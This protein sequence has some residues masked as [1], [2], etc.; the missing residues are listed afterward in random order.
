MTC[1]WL[2][3]SSSTPWRRPC[4][5]IYKILSGTLQSYLWTMKV[6][7]AATLCG[8][9]IALFLSTP[10]I[11]AAIHQ[12][13]FVGIGGIDQWIG[14]DSEN[15]EN[16]IVLVVHGGPGEAQ[17]P[18]AAHYRTWEKQFTV[19]QW[20]QRGAGRT[21]GRYGTQTPDVN[22]KKIAADGLEVAEYLCRTYRKKK[23]ILLGHS[24]GS[25]VA[26]DMVQQ[27]PDLFAA[28]VGTGQA[29]SWAETTHFQFE[30]LLAKARKDHDNKT[31]Q[32]LKAI[33]APDPTNA[34]QYPGSSKNFFDV[35]PPT[36]Q[37]WIRAMRAATPV[38]LGI[39]QEDYKNLI[40]GMSYSSEQVLPD[41]MKTDL[42]ATAIV[43]NTAIFIIQGRDDVTT[44][45]SVA[46]KY[47]KLV[48]APLKEW[49]PIDGG[50]FAFMTDQ[51]QFL[52]ALIK[53]V[54]PVAIHRGA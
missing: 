1:S 10:A 32:A 12:S 43:L 53:K 20:D 33:G 13:G 52:S 9:Q 11:A 36:D 24:W 49:V 38:S 31:L 16:P 26:I 27:R 2:T 25:I 14:I 37:Q 7:L 45:T 4:Y 51:T 39:S 22:L 29:A 21:F 6:P 23:I 5:A 42:P 3:L 19:V 34:Q 8:I 18:Q 48:R 17:W 54:R 44:P 28:Y 46:A 41:Q 15:T 35:M 50:H 40:D 30:L 47:F